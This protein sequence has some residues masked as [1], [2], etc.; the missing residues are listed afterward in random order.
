M[1]T[2]EG[3]KNKIR[4]E[5]RRKKINRQWIEEKNNSDEKGGREREISRSNRPFHHI[6]I[7]YQ[8]TSACIYTYCLRRCHNCTVAE[9]GGGK[10]GDRE[11]LDMLC[12]GED[13][14]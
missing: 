3:Q 1:N 6:R 5:N 7:D 14:I 4:G 10:K 9:V 8:Q 11:G 2:E 13:T 12:W